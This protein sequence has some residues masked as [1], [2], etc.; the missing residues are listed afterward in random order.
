MTVARLISR[1]V[2]DVVEQLE[3]EGDLVVTVERL[4]AV[5]HVL[6]R[7][8]DPR[9]LAYELQRDGWLGRL[10]TRHA[11]EF[12]PGARGGPYG[13]GDRF[14]EFR[15][16]CAVDEAWG[17]VLA[18]ESAASVLGLAQRIPEQEVVALVTNMHFPKAL[19]GEW[20]YVRIEL[21]ESAIM[22][23]D[24]LPSWNL[25]GLLVGIA[26]RPSGYRDVAGLGQWLAAMR[27][28]VNVETLIELLRPMGAATSQRLAYLLGAAE[29]TEGALA[30][31]GAYPPTETAWLGPRQ[32]GGHFDRRSKVNDTLL[33]RYLS[34]GTGS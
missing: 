20:R 4:S 1:G 28:N 2:A 24:S 10:R 9:R 12:L 18:M 27:H 16:Q 23:V 15:A 30:I 26:A 34:V 17:G 33:R 25:E 8:G 6:G 29:N 11:W 31:V 13:A 22:T 32:A 5:L 21:P 7:D 19:A 3:L 14:V